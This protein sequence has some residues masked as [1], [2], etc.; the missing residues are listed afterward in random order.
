MP[1]E[2]LMDFKDSFAVRNKWIADVP[3]SRISP[4][5]KD[6]SLHLTDFTIHSKTVATTLASWKGISLEI[7]TH[8]MQPSDRN[9]AF[10]YMVDINFDNYFALYQW[11]N[12]GSPLENITPLN[13]ITPSLDMDEKSIK[14]IPI[15]VF[16]ISEYKTPIMKITYHNCW[17]KTFNE[18]AL[19]YQDEPDPIKHGFTCVYSNFT[20]E[21]LTH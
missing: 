14:S 13:D 10:S 18:L 2:D 4:D 3:L 19:S 11:S 15:N 12:L 1:G 20:L 8:I 21:K 16:L 5:F 7:P 6:I 17:I 9:I